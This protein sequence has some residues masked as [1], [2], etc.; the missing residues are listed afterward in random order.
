MHVINGKQHGK[1]LCTV[2]YLLAVCV[3]NSLA[4]RT[5]YNCIFKVAS[6]SFT[7]WLNYQPYVLHHKRLKETAYLSNEEQKPYQQRR[8]LDNF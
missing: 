5:S 6:Y 3:V 4:H 2:F 8:F 1:L 7:E